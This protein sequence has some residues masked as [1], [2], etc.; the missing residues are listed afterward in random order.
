MWRDSKITVKI[1]KKTIRKREEKNTGS[2]DRER[3]LPAS[4]APVF[5]A[6]GDR[7]EFLRGG[8]SM[9]KLCVFK[10]NT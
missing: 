3:I 7:P 4:A 5:S 2:G 6:K 8:M 1:L 10:C 9:K